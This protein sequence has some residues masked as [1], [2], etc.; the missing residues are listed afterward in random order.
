MLI[1][2]HIRSNS[3]DRTRLGPNLCCSAPNYATLTKEASQTGIACTDQGV[4]WGYY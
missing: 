3:P 2:M 1:P 4:F